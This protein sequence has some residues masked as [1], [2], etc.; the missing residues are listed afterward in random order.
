MVG[1]DCFPVETG[2][3]VWPLKKLKA[4]KAQMTSNN[5]RRMGNFRIEKLQT[6]CNLSVRSPKHKARN[7]HPVRA[8][9]DNSRCPLKTHLRSATDVAMMDMP[10]TNA[11][12]K[13]L[14][15]FSGAAAQIN[16]ELFAPPPNPKA[17]KI[18]T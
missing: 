16:S 1:A 17:R 9:S 15:G 4:V 18:D 12:S 3:I 11:L 7:S 14:V 13:I 8:L 6:E 10:A 5:C 2:E